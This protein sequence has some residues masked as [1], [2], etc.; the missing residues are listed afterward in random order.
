MVYMSHTY[1]FGFLRDTK[2]KVRD[3]CV[4]IGK[5]RVFDDAKKNGVFLS[6][7]VWSGICCGFFPLKK[8]HIPAISMSDWGAFPSS[9]RIKERG[10]HCRWRKWLY[11]FVN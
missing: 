1:Q 5:F 10:G 3:I 4:T 2:K 7:S 9:S 8:G 6:Q 11:F